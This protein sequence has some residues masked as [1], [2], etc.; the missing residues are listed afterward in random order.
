M[1]RTMGDLIR[2]AAVGFVAIPVPLPTPTALPV[3]LPSVSVPTVVIATP[4]L[5]ALATSDTQTVGVA[6]PSQGALPG[7]A[8]DHGAGTVPKVSSPAANAPPPQTINGLE[9]LFASEL[10]RLKID[11]TTLIPVHQP[12]PDREI[13]KTDLLKNI[14][15]GN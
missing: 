2:L 10:D 3:A 12:N 7:T 1:R 14:G 4:S 5:P 9:R 6:T 13:T 11:Y 15:K 8:A